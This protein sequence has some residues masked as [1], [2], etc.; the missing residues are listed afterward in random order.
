MAS[1]QRP[2]LALCDPGDY[3]RLS[4]DKFRIGERLEYQLAQEFA[5]GGS[6]FAP[7]VRCA[8]LVIPDPES[9]DDFQ[10]H[11]SVLQRVS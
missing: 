7:S 1:K 9:A 5:R 6:P 11:S 2:S 4:W 8:F 10:T 3:T